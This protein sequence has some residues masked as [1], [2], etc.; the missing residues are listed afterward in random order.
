MERVKAN[1]LT[2]DDQRVLVKLI[3]LY[4][5]LFRLSRGAYP[6]LGVSCAPE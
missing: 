1:A 2:P 6:M 5:W 3:E 4:F